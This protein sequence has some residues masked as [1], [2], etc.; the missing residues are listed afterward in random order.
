M[1]IAT[2]IQ[3]LSAPSKAFIEELKRTRN[4]TPLFSDLAKEGLYVLAYQALQ[5]RQ[6]NDAFQLFSSL[7]VT[8]ITDARYMSG[9]AHAAQGAGQLDLATYLHAMAVGLAPSQE[10][11][12]LDLAQGLMAVQDFDMALLVLNQVPADSNLADAATALYERAQAMGALL[13]NAN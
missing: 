6:Y 8:D 12:L 7:V 2:A 10:A 11:Y 1:D 13:A 9:M 3:N 4:A 5:A